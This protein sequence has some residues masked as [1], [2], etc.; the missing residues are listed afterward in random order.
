MF[1]HHMFRLRCKR[2]CY[3]TYVN[4]QTNKRKMNESK[5]H[6]CRQERKK[7]KTLD[8]VAHERL[9]GSD[10]KGLTMAGRAQ[11]ELDERSGQG[12]YGARITASLSL[13]PLLV[14]LA[15]SLPSAVIKF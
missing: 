13:H 11:K 8:R 12:E 15:S 3:S 7:Y 9:T 1:W 5:V 6:T 2:Q 4:E 10:L 14:L